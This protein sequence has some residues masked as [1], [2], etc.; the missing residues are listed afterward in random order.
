MSGIS[1][2]SAVCLFLLGVKMRLNVRE[3]WLGDPPSLSAPPVNIY[4]IS[5]SAL[6]RSDLRE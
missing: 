1:K 5:A 3:L 6:Q 4:R 2:I